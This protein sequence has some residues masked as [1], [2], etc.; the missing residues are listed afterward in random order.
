MNPFFNHHRLNGSRPD[1]SGDVTQ[2]VF[3]NLFNYL[4][5]V[6][7]QEVFELTEIELFLE[8]LIGFMHCSGQARNVI[9]NPLVATII[10]KCIGIMSGVQDNELAEVIHQGFMGD[11]NKVLQGQDLAGV[12]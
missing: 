7:F 10:K 4:R 1:A 6:E 8:M 5:N 11:Y 9:A 12:K 3:T 2:K